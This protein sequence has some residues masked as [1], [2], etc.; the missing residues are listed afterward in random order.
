MTAGDRL[1]N[2]S[3]DRPRDAHADWLMN[4]HVHCAGLAMNIYTYMGMPTLTGPGMPTLT[5][6]GLC[7]VLF[8]PGVPSLVGSCGAITYNMQLLFLFHSH[9]IFLRHCY[10]F[11]PHFFATVAFCCC[12]N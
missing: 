8:G 2:D 1:G 10:I 11:L 7:A 5:G 4:I 6:S 9:I 3:P 12:K